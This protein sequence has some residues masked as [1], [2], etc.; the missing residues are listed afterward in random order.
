[1]KMNETTE[2]KTITVN[3][4]TFEMLD[5]RRTG[6]WNEFLR[7]LIQMNE[8]GADGGDDVLT[9]DHIDDI[10]ASTAT[11]TADELEARLR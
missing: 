4:E 9:T 7:S 6:T 5:N 3:P 1:M 2:R 11:K 10:A 8:S